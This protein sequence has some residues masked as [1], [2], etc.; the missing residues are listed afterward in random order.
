MF[1]TFNVICNVTDVSCLLNLTLILCWV[2]V[3]RRYLRNAIDKNLEL[4]LF[5]GST[6]A[7]IVYTLNNLGLCMCADTLFL[8]SFL[9]QF[10]SSLFPL[11]NA[12]FAIFAKDVFMIPTKYIW[13]DVS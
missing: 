11:G 12:T 5:Q 6:N 4:L 3:H 10:S 2:V 13:K 8:N 7:H 9:L 1:S